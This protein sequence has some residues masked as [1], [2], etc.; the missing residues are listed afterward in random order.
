MKMARAT[1]REKINKNETSINK[2]QQRQEEVANAAWQ[3]IAKMGLEGAS[4]REIAHHLGVTTGTL[5]HYF[6]NKDDLLKVALQGVEARLNSRIRK[7]LDGPPSSKL[8]R[9]VEALLP[10]DKARRDNERVWLTF[11][12][13]AFTKNFLQ[14]QTRTKSLNFRSTLIQTIIEDRELSG[15]QPATSPEDEAD[16][17]MCFTEG[18]C[19]YSIVD[20]GRFPRERQLKLA[21]EVLAAI[22]NHV[23]A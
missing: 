3:V 11:I 21:K 1:N 4:M 15:H 9:I 17:I 5:T 16:L 10:F 2:V 23:R 20:K 14:K 7:A 6:R 12:A 18:L 8:S 19:V 22:R 13:G